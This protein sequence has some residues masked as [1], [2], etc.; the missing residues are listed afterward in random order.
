M[1]TIAG[2]SMYG[3]VSARTVVRRIGIAYSTV[4]LALRRTLRFYPYKIHRYHELLPGDLV[5]AFAIWAFQKMAED[6]DWLCIV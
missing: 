4:W 1:E 2:S 3:E 5:K 6:D